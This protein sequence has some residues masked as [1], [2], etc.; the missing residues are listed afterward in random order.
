MNRTRLVTLVM[1]LAALAA[2]GKSYKDSP[3]TNPVQTDQVIDQVRYRASDA[4]ATDERVIHRRHTDG[5]INLF[6]DSRAEPSPEGWRFVANLQFHDVE[7]NTT[8]L[9]LYQ[10]PDGVP[11]GYQLDETYYVKD[12][13]LAELEAWLTQREARQNPRR[14]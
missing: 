8:K 4:G 11:D 9:V 14:R 3:P 2:C 12:N 13:L 6:N 5:F 1:L 10:T 7:N